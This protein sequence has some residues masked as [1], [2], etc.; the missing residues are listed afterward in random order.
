MVQYDVAS[1]WSNCNLDGVRECVHAF[2]DRRARPLIELKLLGHQT[3]LLP[4]NGA[5]IVSDA[6]RS[7]LDVDR[8]VRLSSRDKNAT[9]PKFAA[10]QVADCIEGCIQRVDCCVQRDLVLR[11][12]RHQLY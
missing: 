5:T 12:Q 8:V 7:P 1:L 2:P 9:S 6:G 4:V 10:I 3:T 11:G